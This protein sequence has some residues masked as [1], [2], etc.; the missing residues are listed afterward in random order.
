M[1]KGLDSGGKIACGSSAEGGH[2]ALAS[3]LRRSSTEVV[4]K[5]MTAKLH[6]LIELVV[7]RR[8]V[9]RECS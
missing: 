3:P 9:A 6:W 4:R 7:L 1:S 2:S 8:D 5:V